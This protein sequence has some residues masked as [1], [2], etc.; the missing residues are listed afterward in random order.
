MTTPFTLPRLLA[1]LW[2]LLTAAT[3]YAGLS[4]TYD[5]NGNLLSSTSD[6]GTSSTYTY[7][8]RN[9][10]ALVKRVLPDGNT[11]E[12][13]YE[14]DIDGNRVAKVVDG[15][16]TNYLIDSNRLYPVV[17]EEYDDAR[18]L[19]VSY[20]YG[21]TNSYSPI[22]QTR[23]GKTY[24]YQYDA[25]G[26]VRSLTASD[27]QVAAEYFYDADGNLLLAIGDAENNFLFDSQQYDADAGLYY[28]RARYRDPSS[29]SFTQ[30]DP[31]AGDIRDPHSLHKYNY[32]HNNPIYFNDPSGKY[33]LVQAANAFNV[34][35]SLASAAT[36]GY[37]IGQF[38]TGEREASP[39]EIGLTILIAAAGPSAGQVVK[40]FANSKLAKTLCDNVCNLLQRSQTIASVIKFR[41]ANSIRFTQDSIGKNFSDGRSVMDLISKLR[42]G[43]VKPD[44]LPPIRIF[45][46]DGK[47]Y[48]L[49]NRRLYATQQAGVKVKTVGA[50]Q[51]EILRESGKKFTTKNDGA[52]VR[53]RKGS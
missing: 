51:D 50:S 1:F 41:P 46:K 47:I 7:D 26:N 44:D 27:G 16:R 15:K 11:V 49:D 12:V 48:T 36:T 17:L 5:N 3:A 21:Q 22:A 35:A 6:D 42:S 8:T 23:N 39:K 40:M 33:S 9:K 28:H 32:A 52:S 13:A 2:M 45:K 25:L 19:V 34:M 4:Q 43:A 53:I 20:A 10:L 38:A 18:T 31:H 37:R 24:H 30:M 14:Y 29:G